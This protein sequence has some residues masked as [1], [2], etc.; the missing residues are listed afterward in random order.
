MKFR[1]PQSEYVRPRINFLNAQTVNAGGND[2]AEL[3][4]PPFNSPKFSSASSQIN[5]RFSTFSEVRFSVHFMSWSKVCASISSADF[6]ALGH[7]CDTAVA[8]GADWIHVDVMDGHSVPKLS[9]GP[10]VVESL[11]RT[12]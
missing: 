5:R 6:A 3:K 8:C 4:A 1:P 2:M 7:D 12:V 10:P 9:I 11:Y